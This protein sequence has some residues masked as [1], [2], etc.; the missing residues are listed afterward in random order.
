M[1]DCGLF[2]V[3]S[4]QVRSP[5]SDMPVKELPSSFRRLCL[6]CIYDVWADYMTSCKNR[7]EARESVWDGVATVLRMPGLTDQVSQSMEDTRDKCYI[8][9][10][11]Q[12]QI[13][14]AVDKASF[15]LF[16]AAAH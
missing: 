3:Y 14:A 11:T 15:K 10:Y 1:C 5:N 9:V 12:Q 13:E 2:P 16:T 6:S 8:S 4:K 7:T